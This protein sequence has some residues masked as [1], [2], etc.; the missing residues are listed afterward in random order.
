[1]LLA[2]V[3]VR[4]Q[5][6]TTAYSPEIDAYVQLNRNLQVN[7]QAKNELGN[8]D[9]I[10]AQIGPSLQFYV[11]PLKKTERRHH[12]RSGPGQTHAA[13]N[14]HRLSRSAVTKPANKKSLGARGRVSRPGE[15]PNLTERQKPP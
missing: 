3:P 15:R 2:F 4:A 8:G 14:L 10:R 6:S 11:K 1:M 13:G 7:F 12:I 9:L 5:T